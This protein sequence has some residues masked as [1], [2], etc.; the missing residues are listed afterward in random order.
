MDTPT[1]ACT[2]CGEVK[3]LNDF[4]RDRRRRDGRD[5]RCLVCKRA[6]NRT[7]KRAC[8][9]AY[10]TRTDEQVARDRARLR[11][12]GVKRCRSCR[13]TLDLDAFTS[14]RTRPDALNDDCRL[15]AHADLLRAAAPKIDELDLHACT[16]CGGPA[17]AID[18]VIPRALGGTDDAH[19]LTPACG[20][21]NG[22]KSATPV[23]E[24]LSRRDPELVARVAAWPVEVVA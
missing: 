18:H 12:D 23:L 6:T 3:Q 15:C 5:S 17:E 22:G 20:A 7:A 19:N 21:C 2:K 13:R 11:P 9:A 4:P 24:W 1:R 14:D 16:Y 8:R 10:A